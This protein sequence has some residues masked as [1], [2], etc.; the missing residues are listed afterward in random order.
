MYCKM[1]AFSA[2][3]L[4]Y[5]GSFWRAR[6]KFRWHCRETTTSMQPRSTRPRASSCSSSSP[7]F[8]PLI[9]HRLSPPSR[10][11]LDI[12]YFQR[13]A[14]VTANRIFLRLNGRVG[15]LFSRLKRGMCKQ[16]LRKLTR[17]RDVKRLDFVSPPLPLARESPYALASRTRSKLTS[18]NELKLTNKTWRPVPRR[19]RLKYDRLVLKSK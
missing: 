5:S 13:S 9:A 4:N 7:F 2:F 19:S 8:R 6:L 11:V 18:N 17:C 14:H 16:R 10:V 15:R 12:A 3:H 1:F